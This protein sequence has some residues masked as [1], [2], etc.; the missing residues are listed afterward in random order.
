MKSLIGLSVM[1]AVVLTA[2]PALAVGHAARGKALFAQ[3]SACHGFNPAD[4]DLGPN[5]KGIVGREAAQVKGYIYSGAMRR[6]AVIWDEQ[7]LNAFLS[8]PSLV[9]P[10]NKMSFRGM[11][12]PEDRADLIAYLKT[13]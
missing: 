11:A 4:N 2:A 1:A 13:R 7:T 5:L 3:C 9:V 6:S 10:R 12:A 8:T